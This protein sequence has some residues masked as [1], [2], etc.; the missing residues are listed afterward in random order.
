MTLNIQFVNMP[1][2]ALR[3]PSLALAQLRSVTEAGFGDRVRVGIRY[4][5][6]DFGRRFGLDL[7]NFVADSNPGHVS[8]FG[9]WFFRQAAFPDLA[10]NTRTYIGRYA[11][12]FGRERLAEFE[13]VLL[14]LRNGLES[15]LDG[16]IEENRL[17]EADLLG[18]TSMFFQNLPSIALARRLKRRNPKQIIVLGGAN[19]EGTMGVELAANVPVVDFVFS[20]HALISFPVF[21]E[22]VLA[23]DEDGLHRIDGVFSR[24]NCRSAASLA[25]LPP[26]AGGGVD[27]ASLRAGCLLEGVREAAEEHDIDAAVPIDYAEFFDS[28]DR[29][30]PGGGLCPEVMFETSRGCWWGQRAHCTFCG[31]NGASMAY[32]AMKPERARAVIADLVERYSSR[33]DRFS[34]VDNILAREHVEGIFGDFRP[35]PNVTFFYEVRADLDA[36]RLRTLAEAGVREVQPGIESLATSTLKLMRK[37]TTAFINIAFLKH[38]A[39]FAIKP[40]W[41]LLVGFPGETAEVY[42]AYK[43]LLPKLFHL[44]PPSGA[45]PVRFDRFSPYFRESRNYGLRLEPLDYYGLCYPFP[46]NAIRNMAYY[47]Q[48]MNFDAGYARD[49]ALWLNELR[50][51]TDQWRRRS[52]TADGLLPPR[53]ALRHG[54]GGSVVEDTRL[55]YLLELPVGAA[56][57]AALRAAIEPVEETGLREAHGEAVGRL[58]QKGLLFQERGRVMSLVLGGE[59]EK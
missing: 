32:R 59:G 47:F 58:L 36:A 18:L 16:L 29:C 17:D 45:F 46:E 21:V 43:S 50:A 55:G 56:E 34:A 27:W 31:L 3:L 4:F 5:N 9:E 54:E 11:Q 53:L 20:G 48:D 26:A 25:T 51:L 42:A 41:N 35:P 52:G 57:V 19:C 37:G 44:P 49:V 38:C 28:L 24:R 39:A 30:F 23:G 22:K 6:H 40:V 7:Y 13:R 12:H 33:A 15:F 2:A 14:P 8:G 10:D 1:F